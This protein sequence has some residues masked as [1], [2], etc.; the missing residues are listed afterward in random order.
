MMN[1]SIDG[2]LQLA[3]RRFADAIHQFV[4]RTPAWEHGVM[5]WTPSLYSRV[6]ASLAPGRT[7][8]N[9]GRR[10]PGSRTPCRTAVLCWLCTVDSTV[11]EWG[12]GGTV[13]ALK[14]LAARQHRPQDT[15]RLNDYSDQLARW[16]VEAASLLNDAVTVVPACDHLT[17]PH[18]G[19]CSS[20]ILAPVGW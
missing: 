12:G 4:D 6:R 16:A 1:E 20:P 15:A 7:G 3:Q 13:H 9:H 10:M 17:W 19:R 18:F 2:T 8:G 11:R 14:E 5:R